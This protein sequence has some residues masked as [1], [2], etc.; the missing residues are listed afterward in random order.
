MAAPHV[1]GAASVLWAKD[2]SKSSDFIRELLNAC[3]ISTS[4]VDGAR[5]GMVDLDY[6]LSVYDEFTANYA[7]GDA[8]GKACVE[9]NQAEMKVYEEEQVEACWPSDKHA[10]AVGLYKDLSGTEIE[11]IK[12]GAKITDKNKTFR[13]GRDVTGAFHGY[14]NYVANY[15][16]MMRMAEICKTEGMKVAVKKAVYP[17]N[18]DKG[19]IGHEQMY[20]AMNSFS[21]LADNALSYK[22]V[23]QEAGYSNTKKNQACLLVGIA[24]HI[25][26]DVYAHRT[27][28]LGDDGK[29]KEIV[30]P[31]EN[32][33]INLRDDTTYK[34]NRWRCA[35]DAA[36]D[37][38]NV[39]DYGLKASAMEYYQ[40]NHKKNVFR[41][42][43]LKTFTISSD[44]ESYNYDPEWFIEHSILD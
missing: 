23:L 3:V 38:V 15:I 27:R 35:K 40:P 28:I 36:Y 29:W 26:M 8:S 31:D 1:T 9:K 24:T 22:C 37:I 7:E 34:N 18:D 19:I 17:A 33:G 25:A 39:W 13:K 44:M 2:K 20:T 43:S 42:V 5:E 21:T 4:D 30:S 16:Y 41:L 6:A 11:I 12:L 10:D 32:G 14:N